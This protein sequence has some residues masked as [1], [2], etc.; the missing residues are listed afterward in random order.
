MRPHPF[1]HDDRRTVSEASVSAAPGAPA[2]RDDRAHKLVLVDERQSE[3]ESESES[4]RVLIACRD[5]LVRAGLKALLNPEAD[6][7][8]VVAAA[9]GQQAVNLAR[10]FHPEVL[11]VDIGSSAIDGVEVTRRVTADA[12]TSAMNVLTPGRSGRDTALSAS[13]RAAASGFLLHD[14]EP[15]GLP[16]GVRATANG[17]AVLSAG[18]AGRAS[19]DSLGNYVKAVLY[20]G[21]GRYD[22]ALAAARHATQYPEDL[23]LFNW[24]LVEL[25]EA[26]TRSDNVELAADALDRLS[27]TTPSSGTE[28]AKAVEARSRALLSEGEAAETL[29]RQAIKRLTRTRARTELARTHL[30]YGEWLRRE[31]R[32]LDAREQLHHADKLFAELGMEAFA[33]RTRTE[34]EATGEQARKRTV[35]TRDD[36]TPQEANVSRLAADGATNKQIADRLFISSSTVDYHLRKAF[37]KLG[38][39][40]R[41]QLKQRLFQPGAHAEMAARS[42]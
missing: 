1:A 29:Y 17:E 13:V 33:E 23:T 15:A 11:L 26:A 10:E 8:V 7:V 21:L 31:R 5:R 9:D 16:R 20:N 14:T 42:D 38:V 37:R 34:L 6:I 4:I 12:N 27:R 32:R 2:A 24:A 18:V 30:L 28:S 22:D 3:R 41:H 40:S 35:E 19:A 36:L 25:I 39:K